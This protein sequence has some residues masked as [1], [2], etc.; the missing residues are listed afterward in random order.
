MFGSVS[1]WWRLWRPLDT[2]PWPL[3]SPLFGKRSGLNATEMPQHGPNDMQP[4]LPDWGP[5]A[6]VTDWSLPEGR[7]SVPGQLSLRSKFRPQEG[8][9]LNLMNTASSAPR[10][11]AGGV[12]LGVLWMQL[13]SSA[14]TRW[15][16]EI[17]SFV[18]LQGTSVP[19]MVLRVMAVDFA[20]SL[21]RANPKSLNRRTWNR[22]GH[23][24]RLKD[25]MLQR[26]QR[27][28]AIQRLVKG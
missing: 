8:H 11:S 6:W 7:L 9:T 14:I 24:G 23:E 13:T 28:M 3:S 2:T 19:I 27:M 5:L 22:G 1:M 16:A 10:E 25:P 4:T 15:N 18:W 17:I 26:N 20:K 21:S 12:S